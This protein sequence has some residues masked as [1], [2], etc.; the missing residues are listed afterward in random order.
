MAGRDIKHMK[1]DLMA[2][3]EDDLNGLIQI[4]LDELATPEVSPV[5][6]GF[7]A[8]S[9]KASTNRPRARDERENFAPWDKIET[10]TMPSGYVKLASGS[11][12]IIQPRHPVPR[13]KLNQPVFIGNTVKYAV[14]ALASP[15]NKIPAY[16]Q[17]EFRDLVKYAFGDKGSPSRIR[18][19]SSQGQ[20]G[21]GLFNLLGTDRK[22]VSYE[23]PG[24]LS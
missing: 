13:F 20:G 6:T 5:L 18:I 22:Y 14:D 8:S 3:L 19:A 1:K 7:F 21:R 4:A 24:E 23:V 15:K 9:W 2:R 12:P 16:V 10:V 17:G 11:Q